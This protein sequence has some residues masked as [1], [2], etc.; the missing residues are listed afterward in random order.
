MNKPSPIYHENR[1][2]FFR[3]GKVRALY[4]R[5]CEQHSTFEV[6]GWTD[7]FSPELTAEWD[8]WAQQVGYSETKRIILCTQE[9]ERIGVTDPN[10]RGFFGLQ[11]F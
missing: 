5:F 4:V 2:D 7:N 8:D 11:C 10:V 6:G 9:L 3:K 1:G